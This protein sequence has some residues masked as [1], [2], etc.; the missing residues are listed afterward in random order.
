MYCKYCEKRIVDDARFCPYCGTDQSQTDMIV[1]NKDSLKTICPICGSTEVPLFDSEKVQRGSVCMNCDSDIINGKC[2]NCGEYIAKY[3]DENCTLCGYSWNLKPV[4]RK[5]PLPS[6]Y[7][8]FIRP[9]MVPTEPKSESIKCPNCGSKDLSANKKGFGLGKALVGGV[10][11][12]GVGLLGGFM[13]SG[14]IQITC[15]K[16]GHR[17]KP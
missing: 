15:L 14:K 12:G 8:E 1:L 5:N 2:P 16:C 13:G 6:C 7:D 4:K 9:I 10:L 3:K 11:L 17:W